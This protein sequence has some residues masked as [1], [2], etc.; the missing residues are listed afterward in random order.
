M[1]R[2]SVRFLCIG[3]HFKRSPK[4][5][6]VW[7]EDQ[8]F[9]YVGYTDNYSSKSFSNMLEFTLVQIWKCF[10]SVAGHWQQDLLLKSKEFKNEL[11]RPLIFSQHLKIN[12]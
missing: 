10:R 6:F 2:I 5:D 1:L 4:Y 9:E 3:L 7:Y 8:K 12:F 11:A